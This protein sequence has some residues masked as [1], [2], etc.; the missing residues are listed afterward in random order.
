MANGERDTPVTCQADCDK[1]FHEKTQ[2][3]ILLLGQYAYTVESLALADGSTTALQQQ[4]RACIL[5]FA[6]ISRQL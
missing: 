6:L 5:L 2:N 3:K 1:V 4:A